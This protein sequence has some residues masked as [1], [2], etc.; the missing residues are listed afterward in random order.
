M[1]HLALKVFDKQCISLCQDTLVSPIRSAFCYHGCTVS[2]EQ[3]EEACLLFDF[4]VLRL[5]SIFPTVKSPTFRKTFNWGS[6]SVLTHPSI[7]GD[8]ASGILAAACGQCPFLQTTSSAFYTHS[9]P[10]KPCV[11]CTQKW[12]ADAHL[13]IMWAEKVIVRDGPACPCGKLRTAGS[14]AQP[15]V[16]TS[17]QNG[18]KA[19][20][21]AASRA[22]EDNQDRRAN[23]C[24]S[25][26]THRNTLSV[27]Q[28]N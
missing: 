18:P 13:P 19:L 9:C 26:E 25:P 21:R 4:M 12:A 17:E 20:T 7:W 3:A 6:P 14:T 2:S 8:C 28:V 1:K 5:S 10:A 23:L 11:C 22:E 16:R 24:P 15:D 27:E